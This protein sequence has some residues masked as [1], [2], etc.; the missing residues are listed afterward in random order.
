MD[1]ERP[2]NARAKNL[3]RLLYLAIAQA[4]LNGDLRKQKAAVATARSQYSQAKLQSAERTIHLFDGK[5]VDGNGTE[6]GRPE[7]LAQTAAG[8]PAL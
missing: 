5:I 7:R 2:S 3:R 1:I 4:Q 8:S 6:I